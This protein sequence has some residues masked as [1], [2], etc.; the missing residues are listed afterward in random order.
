MNLLEIMLSSQNQGQ[1]QQLA[2]N[3]GIGEDQVQ[4]ALAQLV[5][6]LAQGLGRNAGSESGLESLIQA[7]QGGGHQRYAEQPEILAAP[8]TIADGNGILGHLFGSKDVSRAVAAQASADTGIGTD[9][10]KQM[11]PVVASMVMGALSKQAS[12]GGLLG[13]GAS[14]SGMA[15]ML[16][17]L[18]GG[19]GSSSSSGMAGILG[20][21]LDADNDGSV[22]DDLLGM[23][24]KLLR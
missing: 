11:L 21:L 8:D 15:G 14:S 19:L 18:L 7:L 17:G 16:G 13:E 22:A 6:A 10:I 4:S 1:V 3:F 12:S 9:I 24:G 23:A 2:R 20:S 5:P